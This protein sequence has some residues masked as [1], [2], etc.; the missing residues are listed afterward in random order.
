MLINEKMSPMMMKKVF[1]LLLN[2][3]KAQTDEMVLPYL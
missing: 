1:S 2:G 3:V